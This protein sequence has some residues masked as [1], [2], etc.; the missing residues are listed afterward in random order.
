MYS[1]NIA[2]HIFSYE[3]RLKYDLETLWAVGSQYDDISNQKDDSEID[4]MAKYS[5]FL[6]DLRPAE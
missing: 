6:K 1:G 5:D 4:I 2:L 3:A